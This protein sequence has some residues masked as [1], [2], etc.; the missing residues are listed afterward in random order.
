M[1]DTCFRFWSCLLFSIIIIFSNVLAYRAENCNFCCQI[2]PDLPN[3]RKFLLKAWFVGENPSISWSEGTHFQQKLQCEKLFRML[4]ST[5]SHYQL[6]KYLT[7]GFFQLGE[8]E[9][10]EVCIK[11][12]F[13]IFLN[14]FWPKVMHD[15]STP[16]LVLFVNNKV[17]TINITTPLN[18]S[19]SV[20]SV[21]IV[22]YWHFASSPK[23]TR[24]DTILIFESKP[25]N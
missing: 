17:P 25:L 1:G 13:E 7:D 9:N 18:H 11:T 20:A 5:K 8:S 24:C 2:Y 23:S 22:Q 12:D 14:A 21:W 15:S 10:G 3:L 4:I 16:K 6:F 19:A